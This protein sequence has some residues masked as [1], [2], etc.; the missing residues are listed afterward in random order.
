MERDAYRFVEIRHESYWWQRARRDMIADLLRR[1]DV[2]S[3]C[4]WLDLGCGPGGNLDLS[5]RFTSTLVAGVDISPIAIAQASAKAPF[6]SIVCADIDK[7]LPFA[8][9]SFDVVTILNVL[10]HSWIHDERH[11]LNEVRRVLRPRGLAAITEPAFPI[12][13]REMDKIAMTRKRYRLA[14]L[15]RL[16][17]S[18]GLQV[19][20]S[21]Y[22]TSFGFPVILVM[23]A[24]TR[25]REAWSHQESAAA[26]DMK[27][28]T[29]KVNHAMY[30][31]ARLEGRAISYG[32]PIPFGTTLICIARNRDRQ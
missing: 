28:L 32:I 25:L 20:L 7:S 18:S 17:G 24:F 22:F 5:T 4:R 9:G 19:L 21:S 3:P 8:D 31:L 27:E 2:G 29:P 26:I 6:A 10:Y 30:R 15:K 16:C 14:E 1:Y 11:V 12:L 23:K 13:R